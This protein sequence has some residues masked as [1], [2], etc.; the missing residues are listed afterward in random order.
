MNDSQPT[1]VKISQIKYSGEYRGSQADLKLLAD[2]MKK[3]GQLQEIVLKPDYRVV[4]GRR[5]LAAAKSLGWTTIRVHISPTLETDLQYLAAERDENTCRLNYTRKEA[6][7]KARELELLED[8]QAAARK[9]AAQAKKGQKVGA[10]NLP[11]PEG[12]GRV[13]DKIGEAVGMSGRTLEKAQAVIDAAQA[14]PDRYVDLATKVSTDDHPI[15]PVHQEFRDRQEIYAAADKDK[16]FAAIA[17]RLT[18]THDT[19]KAK[20]EYERLRDEQSKD[21][22]GQPIPKRLYKV[23]N[24]RWQD[25]CAE[26]LDY[27][28]Q[29]QLKA[30]VKAVGK[31]SDC[32]WMSALMLRTIEDVM[33][34]LKIVRDELSSISPYAVCTPCGGGGCKACRNSGWLTKEACQESK[35][36]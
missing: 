4:I 35:A 31:N 14:D 32:E 12:K 10:G 34:T 21:K 20:A 13:R 5:R 29:N 9:A 33:S 6:L 19:E 2:S 23:F 3:L 17:D 11:A 8:P 22:V 15:D 7:E 26:A 30:V 1:Q 16:R 25:E 28:L 27:I 24:V 18:A 36:C